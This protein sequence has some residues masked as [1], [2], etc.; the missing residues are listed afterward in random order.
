MKQ[1]RR[2]I[3]GLLLLCLPTG[4]QAELAQDICGLVEDLNAF[5][6]RDTAYTPPPCPDIGFSLPLPTDAARSQAGAYL[7][8]TGQ[9]ELAPDLDLTSAYGQSYLLHELVH[10][11][12][13]EGG[14]Q[15]MVACTGALEAEAYA[16]QAQFL[17]A[18]DLG[19]EA[20]L[21]GLLGAQLGQCSAE[22]EY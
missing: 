6:A 15:H 22:A 7:P 5:I 17:R 14:R 18:H 21:I 10:A 1:F 13:Y 11:A 3:L 8:E 12:Q 19:R 9:I 20:T 16:V 4:A 2:T